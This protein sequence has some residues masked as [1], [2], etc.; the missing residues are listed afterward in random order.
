MPP[1]SKNQQNTQKKQETIP[2]KKVPQKV[3]TPPVSDEEDFDED[4]EDAFEGDIDGNMEED[5]LMF[6][7][8]DFEED[9]DGEE[10]MGD[11][12]A[13]TDGSDD[14]PIPTKNSL[15]SK[16]AANAKKSLAD[17]LAS[18]DSFPKKKTAVQHSSDD[19]SDDSDSEVEEIS[20]GALKKA[21]AAKAEEEKLSVLKAAEQRKA[22]LR[23]RREEAQEYS[24]KKKLDVEV[25]ESD[26]LSLDV[27]EEAQED[28]EMK[29]EEIA[30]KK[31]MGMLAK[32]A[33]MGGKSKKLVSDEPAMKKRKVANVNK[34]KVYHKDGFTIAV[35]PFK[36]D[37]RAQ[38]ID[39][40]QSYVNEDILEG[41]NIVGHIQRVDALSTIVR[42]GKPAAVFATARRK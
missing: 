8:E 12:D 31:S 33:L 36:Q 25:D 2:Q 18:A 19:E 22:E 40:A 15:A 10:D 34:P 4:L 6:A 27:L 16:P 39:M 11:L 5:D 42:K 32:D 29:Q 28:E 9:F 13:L 26:L 24:K 30:R 3:P 17:L 35:N 21:A 23:R 1:R 20:V 14:E 41:R 37:R 7:D 38:M